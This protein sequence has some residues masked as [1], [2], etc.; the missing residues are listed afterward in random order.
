MEDNMRTLIISFLSFFFLA[1]GTSE[2]Q[3]TPSDPACSTAQPLC[4]GEQ[5]PKGDKGDPGAAG[6]KGDKGDPGV[7]GPAGPAGGVGNPG[8]QGAQ[9]PA[10]T[11]GAPG[12]QG[13]QGPVGPAGAS[14]GVTK[15]RL[16]TLTGPNSGTY[17]TAFGTNSTADLFCS[18]KADAYVNGG[19]IYSTN[20]Q[21]GEAVCTPLNV[22]NPNALSGVHCELYSSSAQVNWTIWVLCST[23]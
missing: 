17:V 2:P 4:T 7:A 10:G 15:S 8:P 9:G 19:V 5:G 16:Y 13:I 22:N 14:G 6:P 1:C 3:K 20:G 23:P 18:T 12:P 21:H 11:N